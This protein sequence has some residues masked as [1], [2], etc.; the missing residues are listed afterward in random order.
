VK[1][2]WEWWIQVWPNLAASVLWTL[3]ALWWHHRRVKTH[4]SSEIAKAVNS[5]DSSA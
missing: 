5:S 3:P 1:L 4:V 2:L